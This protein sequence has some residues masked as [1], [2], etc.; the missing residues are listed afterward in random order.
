MSEASISVA[1]PTYG[2]LIWPTPAHPFVRVA[3]DPPGAVAK[4]YAVSEEQLR[5]HA[6]VSLRGYGS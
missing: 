5:R 2:D 4:R 6:V 1:M 3:D